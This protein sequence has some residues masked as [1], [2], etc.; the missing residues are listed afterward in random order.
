M[1]VI[2]RVKVCDLVVFKIVLV[3]FSHAKLSGTEKNS[4]NLTHDS[5]CLGRDLKLESQGYKSAVLNAQP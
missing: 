2:Q 4:E 5:P 1:L 3:T